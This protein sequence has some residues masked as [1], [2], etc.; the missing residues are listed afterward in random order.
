[1]TWLLLRRASVA[2][3]LLC[4]AR[5]FAYLVTWFLVPLPLFTYIVS[6]FAAKRSRRLILQCLVLL[7][8][9]PL[10]LIIAFMV[11][12][13][14]AAFTGLYLP[15]GVALGVVAAAATLPAAIIGSRIVLKQIDRRVVAT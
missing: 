3:I 1:M 2:A 14:L 11:M 15:L 4:G 13:V 6:A 10:A 5:G 7:L 9:V 8:C 12:A